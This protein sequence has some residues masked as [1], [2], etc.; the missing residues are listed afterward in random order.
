MRKCCVWLAMGATFCLLVG[1]GMGKEKQ[2]AEAVA[3]RFHKAIQAKQYDEAVKLCHPD[4]FQRT[5]KSEFR[6]LLGRLDKKLGGFKSAKLAG[7]SFQKRAMA[8][9][10]SGTF[11]TLSY[12][13]AYGKY[14]AAEVFII[15]KPLGG[16]QFSI[17]GYN[18]NSQ[19]LLKE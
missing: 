7:W 15:Y 6:D 16:N 9:G 5:S 14:P 3:D 19:G 12:Q 17:L 18:I 13:V 4:F 10:A 8:G 11:C 1:C 2:A